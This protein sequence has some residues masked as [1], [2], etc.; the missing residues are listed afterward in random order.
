MNILYISGS[1]RKKSNTDMLLNIVMSVTGGNLIKLS[2]YNIKP[3]L[4]CWGCQKTGICPIQ[5]DMTKE[6]IPML[7]KSDGIVIGSPVFFNNVTS[8]VKTFIDRTWCIKGDLRNKI[9]G[10][11]VVGRKYGHESAIT[12]INAFYLKHEMI[13]IN[14]GVSGIGYKEGEIVNDLEAIEASKRLGFRILEIKKSF[15]VI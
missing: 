13:P 2:D 9:G 11:I 3:C 4:A 8:F 6:I 7:L 5:D 14:R 12:A 10:T 15:Q 1:P